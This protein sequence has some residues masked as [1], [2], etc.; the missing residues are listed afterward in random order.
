MKNKLTLDD[1][2]AKIVK[3][4]YILSGTLTV[5]IMTLENGFMVTGESACVDIENFDEEI[6]K[7]L[8]R[9]SA[10]EKVWM[11]EGY[12]LKQKLYEAE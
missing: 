8:A 7:K 2:L 5:C 3:T 11:L 1:I 4:D 12:L 6:G 9:G 10:I